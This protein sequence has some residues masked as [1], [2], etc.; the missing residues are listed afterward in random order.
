MACTLWQSWGWGSWHRGYCRGWAVVAGR[1]WEGVRERLGKGLEE[2]GKT[3][4]WKRMAGIV[5]VPALRFVTVQYMV[6]GAGRLVATWL[7]AYSK[8]YRGWD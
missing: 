1:G 3:R 7:V 2:V 6:G 4:G 8:A 5:S